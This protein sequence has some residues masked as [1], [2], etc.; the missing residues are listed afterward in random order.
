MGADEIVMMDSGR[1]IGQGS[2]AELLK[3]CPEYREIAET[4]LGKEAVEDV[5]E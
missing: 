5:E 1:V 4:Q 3:S 2:H